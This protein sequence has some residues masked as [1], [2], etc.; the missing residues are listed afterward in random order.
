MTHTTPRAAGSQ[1]DLS[2]INRRQPKSRYEHDDVLERV[3]LYA[4]DAFEI[5]IASNG[6]RVDL[7]F[8]ARLPTRSPV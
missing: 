2:E 4:I 1:P 3:H 5:G 7:V 8:G 6:G